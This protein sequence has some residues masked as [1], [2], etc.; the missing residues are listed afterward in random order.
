MVGVGD[1]VK[2]SESTGV[3]TPCLCVK[4]IGNVSCCSVIPH[5]VVV[6]DSN[7]N[8]P[9]KNSCLK[10]IH[11]GNLSYPR[12]PIL[13]FEALSMFFRANPSAQLKVCMLGVWDNSIDVCLENYG[14]KQVVSVHPPVDYL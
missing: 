1:C 5:V 2:A 10:I 4:K 3:V 8:V 7:V 12:N 13:F 11:S 6:G 9:R 14:L